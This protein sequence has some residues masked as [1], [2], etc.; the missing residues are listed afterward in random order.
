[1]SKLYK[2]VGLTR[3]LP[4]ARPLGAALPLVLALLA[5]NSG[6]E[7]L[8]ASPTPAQVATAFSPFAGAPVIPQ[9]G[10]AV[11]TAGTSAHE[12]VTVGNQ[13]HYRSGDFASSLGRGFV[14][15]WRQHP[16]HAKL[17]WIPRDP[18][19]GPLH[20]HADREGGGSDDENLGFSV[21][22]LPGNG[23]FWPDIPGITQPGHW[24][25][26]LTAGTE[27]GCFVVDL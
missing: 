22:Y 1:M 27:S 8:R 26:T 14:Q 16:G 19:Q 11:V 2:P 3:Q 10:W 17:G 24:T 7:S 18:T 12:C 15:D 13:D 5:C 20:V 23:Y 6:H 9:P 25:F 21:S 4:R